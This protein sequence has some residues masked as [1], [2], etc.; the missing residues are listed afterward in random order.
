L[1][2]PLR[3]ESKRGLIALAVLCIVGLAT[4]ASVAS[5]GAPWGK[6]SVAARL[7]HAR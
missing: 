1:L 6:D 7:L 5:S 4:F 2:V 3:K